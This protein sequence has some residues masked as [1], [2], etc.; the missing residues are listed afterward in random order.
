VNPFWSPD[1]RSIAFFADGQLKRMDLPDGKPFNLCPAGTGGDWLDAGRGGA[2]FD[3]G[4][5]VEAYWGLM[6]V[7]ANGGE[8]V[9]LAPLDR[10]RGEISLRY[11]AVIG[12]RQVLYHTQNDDDTKSELR[13]LSLDAPATSTSLVRT[14]KQG[15]YADGRIFY[16]RHGIVVAQTLDEETGTLIGEPIA[17]TGGVR[18]GG[19]GQM[20]FTA[21]A[22]S[23]A[24]WTVRPGQSQLEWLDRV[25][26][27]LASLGEPEPL[28]ALDLSPDDRY[29]A[30]EKTLPGNE[31]DIWI[32]DTA[33][34]SSELLVEHYAS[35]Q[36]PVWSPDGRRIA[37]QSTRG[38]AGNFNLY[39]VA[40][41]NSSPIQTIVEA[42][43][44]LNPAGWTPDGRTFAWIRDRPVGGGDTNALQ[45]RHIDVR[46]SPVQTLARLP[47]RAALISPDGT[48]VAY[49]LRE[50]GQMNL[51]IDRFP[52]LGPRHL[53]AR[54]VRGTARWRADSREL[55]F[56]SGNN[57][58]ATGIVPGIAPTAGSAT[59]LFPVLGED[60]DV[61]RDGS[62]FLVAVPITQ[63]LRTISVIRN[64]SPSSGR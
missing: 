12:R 62:R 58:M 16:D 8:P 34:N 61:T 31:A 3:D 42:P 19:I 5:I 28:G 11:P 17:I 14:R 40:I 37:F 6:R 36:G 47:F 46:E 27:K 33:S 21:A 45:V 7:S 57:L 35:D 15:V 43:A 48:M 32:L 13:L 38:T 29:A 55:F 30:V 4:T 2:W 23:M 54:Q 60:W 1:G 64:W 39:V 53:V 56:T 52:A 26:R 20:L 18:M 59:V 63:P 41:G 9:L 22:G 24:W 49:S 44:S 50:A 51:Y 10:S 25:G